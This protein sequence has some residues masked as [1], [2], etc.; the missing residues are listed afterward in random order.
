MVIIIKLAP[1]F[2]EIVQKSKVEL[3]SEGINTVK[4]LLDKLIEEYGDKLR[5]EI[6]RSNGKIAPHIAILINGQTS[7]SD[8]KI[9]DS[10]EV[11]IIAPVA[12]G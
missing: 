2:R 12:G 3:E 4:E 11:W 8:T 10:D 6:F 9:R 5:R 7:G 1:L